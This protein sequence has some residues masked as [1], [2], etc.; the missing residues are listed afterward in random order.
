MRHTLFLER[1]M[2]ATSQVNQLIIELLHSRPPLVR[3]ICL[4]TIAEARRLPE[5]A[6]VAYLEDEVRKAVKRGEDVK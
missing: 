2:A 4:K 5:K 1:A 6:L 3:R